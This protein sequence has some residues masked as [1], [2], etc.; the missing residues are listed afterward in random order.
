MGL[1]VH[2]LLC[3]FGLEDYEEIMNE[4]V[5]LFVTLCACGLS[6]PSKKRRKRRTKMNLIVAL[7][8]C[9]NS[10]NKKEDCYCVCS[11]VILFLWLLTFVNW[12]VCVFVWR[13]S[14]Y[15]FL[16]TKDESEDEVCLR[17]FW[18]LLMRRKWLRT[19]E[20]GVEDD[21][22]VCLFHLT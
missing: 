20:D 16:K 10:L 1:C 11:S 6:F 14:M 12:F 17:I 8:F 19:R 18:G 21:L 2:L 13:T 4:I 7:C 22:V 5:R 9:G 15:W 3:V